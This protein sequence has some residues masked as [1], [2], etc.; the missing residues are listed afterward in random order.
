MAVK[1]VYQLEPKVE[2]FPARPVVKG[3]ISVVPGATFTALGIVAGCASTD[4][5]RY[6]LNGVHFTPDDG[7][8]IIATDGRR[9]AGAPARVPAREFILP[10]TA[11]HVLAH[12]DFAAR[13]AAVMQ[14][15]QPKDAD[16]IHIQ[17]RS[18][19]HTLIAKTIEGSYPRYRNVIPGYLPESVTLPESH[20]AAVISWLRSL[21]GRSNSV[22]L[23]WETPGHLTLTHRDYDTVGATL[24]VPVTIEG[25]PPAISFDPEYLAVAF[26]IGATLHLVDNLNPGMTTDP[27][28]NFCVVMNKRCVSETAV[29]ASGDSAAAA[30]TPLQ[31][32]Q[33]AAA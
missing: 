3:P 9:L 20:R 33:A 21:K 7:G 6:V 14:P 1:T 13:D 12:P 16:A 18:G 8:R 24:Q 11:V 25:S 29:E 26:V 27:T 5:T 28:G 19:P 22:R 10:N 2:E 31:H 23:T 15:D 30:A 32:E 17:F 4:A